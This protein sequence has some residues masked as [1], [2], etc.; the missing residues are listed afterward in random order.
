MVTRDN[1]RQR[2][3]IA[4]H[5]KQ[6]ARFVATIKQNILPF[7]NSGLCGASNRLYNSNVSLISYNMKDNWTSW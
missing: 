2:T 7:C 3:S 1:E 6:L 4:K 5:K